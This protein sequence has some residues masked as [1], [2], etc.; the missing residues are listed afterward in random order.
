MIDF[1]NCIGRGTGVGTPLDVYAQLLFYVKVGKGEF[2]DLGPTHAAFKGSVDAAVFRGE[3][4]LTLKLLEEGKAE[5]TL[6]NSKATQAT[7][8]FSGK[9]LTMEAKFGT[10]EQTIT[11]EPG[12]K[13]DVETYLNVTGAQSMNI[14]LAPGDKPAVA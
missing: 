13:G 9:R 14:H 8:T 5:V 4:S 6:N 11:F 3:F 2:L 12:G 7:Y 10:R 1:R